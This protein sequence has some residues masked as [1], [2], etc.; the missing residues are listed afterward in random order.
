MVFEQKSPPMDD[1]KKSTLE[2]GISKA[3][4]SHPKIGKHTAFDGRYEVKTES[5]LVLNH[6][7]LH[8]KLTNFV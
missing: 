7:V 3:W 1:L 2:K 6:I 4:L 8:E 5:P